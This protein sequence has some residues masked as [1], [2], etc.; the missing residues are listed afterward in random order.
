MAGLRKGHSYSR[1]KN[2]KTEGLKRAYTRKSKYK[3][4]NFIRS[5][6][7][8]KVV[9][10]HMGDVKNNYKY[11][12]MLVTLQPVQVR[13]NALEASRQIVH[14][15]LS[16]SLGNNYH[17]ILRVYPHQILRE[18]KMIT[19]AGADRMQT[20]M[21]RSFGQ[22]IGIA[23]R[24]NK[25]QPVFS[26]DVSDKAHIELAKEALKLATPRMPGKYYITEEEIKQ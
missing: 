5:V 3:G 17:L 14:R 20:G 8:T 19:G 12:I 6:P 7:T 16:I 9:R 26:V 2:G 13:H 15:R 11:R 24:I 18:N 21:Q 22:A 4:K 23:A 10:Y 1:V 25:N